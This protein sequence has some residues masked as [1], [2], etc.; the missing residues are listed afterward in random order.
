MFPALFRA[1]RI[2]LYRGA[3]EVQ[4]L[5]VEVDVWTYLIQTANIVVL[6][7]LFIGVPVMLLY[8]VSLL[9]TIARSLDR[10]ARHLDRT[11]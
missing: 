6:A 11:N 3:R 4:A 1:G 7:V 5:P 2:S 8:T 10:I 9:R